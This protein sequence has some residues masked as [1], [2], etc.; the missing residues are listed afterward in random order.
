M[1]K[2]NDIRQKLSAGSTTSQL[3]DQGYAKSSVFSVARKL[4][5]LRPDVNTYQVSD[6]LQELRHAKEM[7][8][9]KKEI[10]DLEV[11]NEKLP[12]RVAKLETDIQELKDGIIDIWTKQALEAVRELNCPKHGHTMGM[13][14][15]CNTCNYEIGLGWRT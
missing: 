1:G 5:N 8:K 12:E 9:L 15:K 14:V 10:A 4:R 11:G 3:I 13:V 7:M 6:E 2:L